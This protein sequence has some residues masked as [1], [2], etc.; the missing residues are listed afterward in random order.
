MHCNKHRKRSEQAQ[1]PEGNH[2]KF[3]SSV[4]EEAYNN[5][6]F[7]S[8]Q[9]GFK[10]HTVLSTVLQAQEKPGRS[11]NSSSNKTTSARED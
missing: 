9:Q 2:T 3:H 1:S 4:P 10:Q 8:P 11:Q 7:P 5:L 6:A